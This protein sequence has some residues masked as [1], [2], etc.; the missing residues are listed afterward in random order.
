MTFDEAQAYLVDLIDERRSR[1]RL[2]LDRM[3]ALLDEL[4][5]PHQAYA[6]VHV[7][8]TSG[9]GSTATMIAAALRG[10]Q[11]RTGLHT[12]PHLHSVTERAWID[13]AAIGEERFA[14]LLAEMMPA[15]EGVTAIA[16]RPS[17]YET[18]L[19]LAFLYFARERVDV[20]VIEVG[21]GGRLDGTNVIVPKVAV[22][23]SVGYD[24]TEILG[25]SIEAIA[26][27][28]A[29]IAKPAVPL[30]VGV[31]NRE[32]LD[33]IERIA[34]KTGAPVTL[35]DG[36][37]ELVPGNGDE[38]NFRVTTRAATYDVRL[39][40][41][42][43]FQRRNAQCAIAALEALPPELR[44]SSADV[45]RGLTTVAIPGRMEIFSGTPAAVLDIAHNAEKAQ[46]LADALRE[47]FPGKRFHA[48]VAIGRDKDARA[49]VEALAPL[50]E[51]LTFTSFEAAGRYA[52]TPEELTSIARPLGIAA[53]HVD[54]PHEAFANVSEHVP[55]DAIVL[56]TGSTFVVSE[57]RATLRD[58]VHN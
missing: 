11:K 9:K 50:I 17:Y 58:K 51:S 33:V 21:L 35:V 41:F 40:V 42:G 18:L 7:G 25:E 1:G 15:L 48:I 44:P 31:E 5:N 22:I 38:R 24:H 14:E 46:H 13:G 29:G 3:R 6:T 8:G 16:G 4:G 49:I 39:P 28:K 55:N 37:S 45:E 53:T 27:E 57:I 47:H 2:G 20:A 10:S 56:V 19:A 34:V 12:K 52:I 32:A 43:A 30:V 26:A 54:D 36:V 23:T